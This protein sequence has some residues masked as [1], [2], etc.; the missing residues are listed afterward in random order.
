MLFSLIPLFFMA[1]GLLP[2]TL[3]KQPISNIRSLGIPELSANCPRQAA[4]SDHY[5]GAEGFQAKPE[6][7]ELVQN[8]MM[9]NHTKNPQPA[10]TGE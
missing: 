4:V 5:F 2:T 3:A 6:K 7:N 10:I 9:G 8:F 1:D